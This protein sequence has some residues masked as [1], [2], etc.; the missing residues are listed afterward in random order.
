[1]S[2]AVSICHEVTKARKRN[3]KIRRF[4]FSCFRGRSS[5]ERSH[6][7][8][9]RSVLVGKMPGREEVLR[10]LDRIRARAGDARGAREA[11]E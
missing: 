8:E 4:V 9:L 3:L 1:M 5:G 2:R 11:E 7:R 10:R 6:L